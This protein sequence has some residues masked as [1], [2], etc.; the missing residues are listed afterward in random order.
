MLL[1]NLT[2][3]FIIIISIVRY[4]LWLKIK[5]SIDETSEDHSY[6]NELTSSK[7]LN[8]IPTT[9]KLNIRPNRIRKTY[10]NLRDLTIIF[11]FLEAILFF[12]YKITLN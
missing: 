8:K 9:Q 10:N 2:I 1:M 11:I 6:Y 7:F 12:I 4:L 3:F 5:S